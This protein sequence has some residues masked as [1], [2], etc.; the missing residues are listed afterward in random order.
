MATQ[1]VSTEAW[2]D[3]WI[4]HSWR[5]VADQD[6]LTARIAYRYELTPP[7]LW[8][9]QQAVEKYLKAIL[10]FNRVDTRDLGHNVVKAFSRLANVT[11][12][13]FNFPADI[14]KFIE[15]INEEGPNRY[16]DYPRELR[17]DALIGLDRTAWHLR[18]YC[19]NLRGPQLA[20]EIAKLAV[21]PLQQR[22]TFRITGG[23]LEKLL[24]KRSA[25]RAHLVW[26]NFWYGSRPKRRIKNFPARLAWSQPLTFMRPEVYAVVKNLVK[27]DPAVRAHLETVKNHRP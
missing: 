23:W 10:L 27:L 15:Y 8:S 25:T 12:I 4:A 14:Q 7:F 6:Y 3:A 11:A 9:S 17:P 13:P 5:D 20:N 18:R 16:D 1:R 2:V 26:K 19:Y 24:T 21:D 22:R